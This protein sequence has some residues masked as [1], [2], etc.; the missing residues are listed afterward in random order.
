MKP[1]PRI[2]SSANRRATN[3]NSS[4]GYR[5]KTKARGRSCLIPSVGAKCCCITQFATTGSDLLSPF[6]SVE[7]Y[8][9]TKPSLYRTIN[10]TFARRDDIG[11]TRHH[12]G[13]TATSFR[14]W[15]VSLTKW[16]DEYNNMRFLGTIFHNFGIADFDH[17]VKIQVSMNHWTAKH[18][19]PTFFMRQNR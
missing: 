5:R 13:G 19:P 4:D 2:V 14:F 18:H 12:G 11:N 16:M 7:R 1:P 3:S 15:S 6:L 8:G 9:S 17:G 10:W